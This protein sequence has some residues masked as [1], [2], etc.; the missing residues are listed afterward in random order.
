MTHCLVN[1]HDKLYDG[2][3]GN[4]HVTCH[5][6]FVVVS[7]EWVMMSPAIGNPITCEICTVICFLHAKD[8]V[9]WN[10]SWIM[11]VKSVMSEITI[12]ISQWCRMNKDGW[13]NAH[14]KD[15]SVRPSVVSDDLIHVQN[16]D[17]N[18]CERQ[19]FIVSKILCGF[20]QISLTVHYMRLSQAM[21]SQVLHKMDSKNA[22]RCT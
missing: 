7:T 8:M 9:L 2:L 5:L 17:Q 19:C 21:L 6:V 12:C 4:D 18:V 16:V 14:G 13:T 20:P 1:H 15:W 22:H 11:T 3:Q 10:K